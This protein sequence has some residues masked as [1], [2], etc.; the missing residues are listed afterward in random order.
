MQGFFNFLRNFVYFFKI[1]VLIII[2]LLVLYWI[3]NLL[4]DNWGWLSFIAP[5]LDVFINWGEKISSG[6]FNIFGAVFEFK[7]MIATIILTIIYHA[8]N[9]LILAINELESLFDE[10]KRTVKRIQESSMNKKSQDKETIEQLSIKRFQIYVRTFPKVTHLG[11]NHINMEEQN[12]IMNKFLIGKTS[13]SPEKFE[14]GFLY[15]F[16]NFSKID[17]ILDIFFKLPA[18]KAPINYVIAVRL[19]KPEE[20]NTQMFKKLIELKLLNKI[21]FLADVAY[22]YKF[23]PYRGYETSGVGVYRTENTDFEVH[24]FVK[25]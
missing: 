18:S 17:S 23:N 12:H 24:E 1:I 19:L 6:A 10:G 8:I 22:R 16:E 21:S 5:V 15:T 14:D 25:K 20:D 11:E 3:Q 2:M 9:A 4:S 7:Y 13:I